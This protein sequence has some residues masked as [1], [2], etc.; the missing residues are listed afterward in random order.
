[1]W[2]ITPPLRYLTFFIYQPQAPIDPTPL[3][4]TLWTVPSHKPSQ[5]GVTE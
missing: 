2:P 1:V 5:D 3:N 4:K